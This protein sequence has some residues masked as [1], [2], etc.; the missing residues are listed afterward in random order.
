MRM[1]WSLTR[2][3]WEFSMLDYLL[4]VL[5][6]LLLHQLTSNIKPEGQNQSGKDSNVAHIDFRKCVRVHRF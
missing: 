4:L 5:L 6:L 3:Q 1:F 2:D